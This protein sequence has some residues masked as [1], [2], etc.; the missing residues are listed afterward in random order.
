[1]PRHVQ[2]LFDFA[3]GGA[4]HAVLV[5]KNPVR[6]Y[7]TFSPYPCKQGCLISVALS[8]GLLQPGVTRHRCPMESGLSSLSRGCPAIRSGGLME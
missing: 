6:S 8:L 5:A 4:C 7:R 3:P 2:L 1:V